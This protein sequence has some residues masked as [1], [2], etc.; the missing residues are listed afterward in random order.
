MIFYIGG[1]PCAGKST[2]AEHMENLTRCKVLHLDDFLDETTKAAAKDGKPCCSEYYALLNSENGTDKVWMRD[3]AEQCEKEIGIYREA[4][5]YAW[6]KVQ[7]F[8][9]ECDGFALIEGCQLMPEL[10]H[11]M[12]IPATEYICMIPDPEFLR[13]EYPKRSFVDIILK[14]AS[15]KKAAFDHW[16][17]RDIL[18]ATEMEKQARSFGYRVKITK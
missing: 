1:S 10:M 17:Q 5:P 16:M 11:E 15:D 2:A 8:L 3:P 6:E 13:E 18:F 12:G 9:K 4:F 7:A 14:D